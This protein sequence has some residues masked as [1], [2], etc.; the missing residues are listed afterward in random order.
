M[1]K[2]EENVVRCPHCREVG[3]AVWTGYGR[4]WVVCERCQRRIRWEEIEMGWLL[5]D[6]DF[7]VPG[8][9]QPAGAYN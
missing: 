8:V 1:N 3:Q 6:D 9:T 2:K 5:E 7:W 4:N